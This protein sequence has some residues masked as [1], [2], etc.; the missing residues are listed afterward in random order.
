MSQSLTFF[1]SPVMRVLKLVSH[2]APISLRKMDPVLLL[3]PPIC[4]FVSLETTWRVLISLI[5][6]SPDSSA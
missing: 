3:T 4:S 5:K 2:I 1:D 6:S